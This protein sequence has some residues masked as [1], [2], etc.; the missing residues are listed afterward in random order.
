MNMR[1][2]LAT[3]RGHGSAKSGVHHWFAQRS[4]ALLL[5]VLIGWLVFAMVRLSGAD[6]ASAAGF[7]GHPVNATF[8]I[9]L[10]V[11][12][13]YHAMLGLQV[14]IEDYVHRPVLEGVL[15]F[16]TRA[17]AYFSMALGI[18]Y[19]LKLALGA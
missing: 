3:A 7:I 17:V 10:I 1:N 6:H 4:T 15:H 12:L 13:V 14:V 2:P 11:T 19:V 9:L 18:I 5:L 8:L 16:I